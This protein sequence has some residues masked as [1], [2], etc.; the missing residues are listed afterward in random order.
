MS[1]TARRPITPDDILAL[2]TIRDVCLSPDGGQIAFVRQQIDQA[3][4]EYRCAI[5]LAPVN[6]DAPVPFT[7]GPKRDTAPAWSP[8]GRTLAFL[9]DRDGERPQ[10]YVIPA[11]GGE[12]RKLTALEEGAGPASWSP[13]GST[14]A[15]PS[16]VACSAV[17]VSTTC[18]SRW[19]R[20]TP[21]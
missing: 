14:P 10:L 2:D 21:W 17:G 13:D 1:D 12:A 16:C 5:W 4:D 11:G 6:G 20:S 18:R 15:M 3:G 19:P 8:D 7:R 9:S